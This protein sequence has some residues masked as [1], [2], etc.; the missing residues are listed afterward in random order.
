MHHAI[1]MKVLGQTH[2]WYTQ[3]QEIK[4]FEDVSIFMGF[5]WIL[6]TLKNRTRNV[7]SKTKQNKK[8]PCKRDM[9]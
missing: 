2:M 6:N 4:L 8:N 7:R 5:L 9:L 1:S 3:R